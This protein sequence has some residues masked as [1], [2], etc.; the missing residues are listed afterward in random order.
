MYHLQLL[1]GQA[2][3]SRAI[4]RIESKQIV[5]AF[6]QFILHDFHMNGLDGPVHADEHVSNY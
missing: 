5:H 6:I 1:T 4:K 2:Q 3:D